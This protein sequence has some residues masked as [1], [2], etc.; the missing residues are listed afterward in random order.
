MEKPDSP[1][2][3]PVFSSYKDIPGV[4]QEEINAIEEFRKSGRSFIYGA[5]LTSECFEDK[6]RMGGFTALFCRWLGNLFDLD[7]TPVIYEWVD[8][9]E[10]LEAGTIDF[11]G[12][13]TAAPERL[14]TYSMTST[15]AQRA[16]I[17]TQLSHHPDPAA[18][19]TRRR[20]RFG[21]LANS[22]TP[23]MIQPALSFEIDISY[24]DSAE[25]AYRLLREEMIDA[26]IE[27]GYEGA[28]AFQGDFI[29]AEV[30][31]PVYNPVSLSA[32]NP[33]LSPVISVVQKYL[34]QGALQHLVS[35]YNQGYKE[36]FT[37]C[38]HASLTEKERE[39]V[40]ARDG[41][42]GTQR[43]IPFIME[44]DNYPWAFYNKV[45]GTWQGMAWDVLKKI[46]EITGLSFNVVSGRDDTWADNLVQLENGT[47]AFV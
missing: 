21:F 14:E 37:Y 43:P 4:S 17:I 5:Y 25:E 40:A 22:I 26:F 7:F 8:L 13:L 11:T 9:L 18:I 41:S 12:E 39:Y 31:P 20:P 47:G 38:F 46:E 6:G 44:R 30:V 32:R 10:G 24:V 27:D 1:G 15:I 35:L 29:T 45:D 42:Q 23:S 3:F 16:V 33:E 2:N 19:S 28:G 34:N 36:Y